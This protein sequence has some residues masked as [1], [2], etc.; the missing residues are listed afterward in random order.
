[1]PANRRLGLLQ[2]GASEIFPNQAAGLLSGIGKDGGLR[3]LAQGLNAQLTG[4]AEQ[5][6]DAGTRHVEANDG[7]QYTSSR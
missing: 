1:M 3:P 6:Q 7:R 5:V 4:A 2:T